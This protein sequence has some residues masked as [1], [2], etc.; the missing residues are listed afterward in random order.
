MEEQQQDEEENRKD[1]QKNEKV[2]EEANCDGET[3]C[4]L[5]FCYY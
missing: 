5:L 3:N 1:L 2:D 4:F